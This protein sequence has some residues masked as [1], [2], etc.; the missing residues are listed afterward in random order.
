MEDYIFLLIAIALSIFGA[1]N[2]NKKKRDSVDQLSGKPVAPRN[3][4][5][6]QLLGENFHEIVGN[7]APAPVPV[8]QELKPVPMAKPE[9]MAKSGLYH[10]DFKSTLP[11]RKKNPYQTLVRKANVEEIDNTNEMEESPS[12]L[13]DFSIRRAFVYSEIMKTKFEF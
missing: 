12:Y 4:F 2:K 11:E 8:R 3:S 13:E 9:P 7:E 10:T 6:E 1:I 5:L